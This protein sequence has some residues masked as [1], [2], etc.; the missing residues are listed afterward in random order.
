[1]KQSVKLIAGNWKMNGLAADL[2]EV[3]ALVS[4]LAE[5]W[6]ESKDGRLKPKV[7]NHYCYLVDHYIIPRLGR[8]KIVSLGVHDIAWFV[9]DMVKAGFKAWTIRNCRSAISRKEG[10]WISRAISSRDPTRFRR[11][12]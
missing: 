8:K 10:H 11:R 6:L 9:N 4:E 7:H 12:S 5:E 1:M 3:D 2:A